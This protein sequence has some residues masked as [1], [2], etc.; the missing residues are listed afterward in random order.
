MIRDDDD[1][2]GFLIKT[3]FS[4][5]YTS[6]PHFIFLTRK[7]WIYEKKE[8]CAVVQLFW[9]IYNFSL[10]PP[11]LRRYPQMTLIVWHFLVFF[12]CLN[13]PTLRA[14]QH[15]EQQRQ[16]YRFYPFS[17]SRFFS[18]QIHQCQWRTIVFF[19]LGRRLTRWVGWR[20]GWRELDFQCSFDFLIELSLRSEIKTE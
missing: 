2:D 6:F 13:A 14:W 17:L 4:I 7:N 20:D 3:K 15:Q 8:I 18:F 19:F 10:L 16:P 9:N 12:C 11:L 1:S 5:N